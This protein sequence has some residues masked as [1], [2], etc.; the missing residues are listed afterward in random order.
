MDK[1]TKTKLIERMSELEYKIAIWGVSNSQS[2]PGA[3]MD[4][5]SMKRELAKIKKELGL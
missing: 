3:M 2:D 1:E 4:L 5:R